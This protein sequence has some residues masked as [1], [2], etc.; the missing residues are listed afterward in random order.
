M[1]IAA[2]N[3]LC[4]ITTNKPY[5]Y[6]VRLNNV[7]KIGFSRNV[8]ARYISIKQGKGGTMMPIAYNS[9]RNDNDFELLYC[10]KGGQ[11]VEAA[12]HRI[13]WHRQDVGEWFVYDNVIKRL[14][15]WLQKIDKDRPYWDDWHK[16][17]AIMSEE[18]FRELE[19]INPCTYEA[20]VIIQLKHFDAGSQ[21]SPYKIIRE[22]IASA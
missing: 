2:F 4:N 12:L 18:R 1:N 11:N 16:M 20:Y 8:I 9:Y 5:V 3:H 6:F 13:L 21:L 19:K 15:I 14:I 10:F 22:Q 7:V 17:K